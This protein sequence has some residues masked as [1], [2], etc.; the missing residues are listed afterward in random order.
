MIESELPRITEKQALIETVISGISAGTERMW[1]DGSSSAL[2]SGRRSYPYR[3]GYEL[4]GRAVEVGNAFSGLSVGDRVF[5]MKPHA[6]HAILGPGDVWF[7]LPDHVSDQDALAIS[8]TATSIHAI[9]R[10]A[11]TLGDAVAVAGLGVLGMIMLQVLSAT[12]GGPVVALTQSA[13]KIETALA[14]GATHALT[15]DSLPTHQSTLPPLQCAFECS[16]VAANVDRIIR[17]PRSQGAVVLAG[18][19]NEAIALDGEAIFAKELTII[20]V[21]ATGG[22]QE[23]NEYNRWDRQR[24]TMLAFSLVAAGKVKVAHLITHSFPIDQFLRAYQLIAGAAT[25]RAQP[26]QVCLSWI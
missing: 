20:G 16:G 15:Y 22:T 4:V 12:I 6:S 26:L 5:A 10:S 25:G 18:F 11:I 14:N 7:R 19:Y 23:N 17:V 8:L 13:E 9:H 2:K 3:P 24:N 21:R 1:F